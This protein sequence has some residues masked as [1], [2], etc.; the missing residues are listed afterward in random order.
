MILATGGFKQ[1][2]SETACTDHQQDKTK[3]MI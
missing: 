2:A 1:L 3:H